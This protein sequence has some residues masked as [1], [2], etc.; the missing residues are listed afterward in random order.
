MKKLQIILKVAFKYKKFSEGLE[1]G[2]KIIVIKNRSRN[3]N[4]KIIKK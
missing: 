4:G 3:F 2:S 1:G